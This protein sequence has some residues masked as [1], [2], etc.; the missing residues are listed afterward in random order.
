MRRSR[1]RDRR[2]SDMSVIAATYNKITFAYNKIDSGMNK[3]IVS[4]NKI[5]TRV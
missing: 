3:I 4:Y 2:S 1:R 5:H